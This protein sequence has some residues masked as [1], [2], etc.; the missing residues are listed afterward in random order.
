[1]YH[2]FSRYSERACGRTIRY[3][4]HGL[5]R[6]LEYLQHQI[7]HFVHG[8]SEELRQHDGE[9][10]Q[11]RNFHLLHIHQADVPVTNVEDGQYGLCFHQECCCQD[12]LQSNHHP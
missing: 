4:P 2:L 11:Q 9:D 1:M 3:Q 8:Q 10:T 6:F 5:L 7:K 12:L